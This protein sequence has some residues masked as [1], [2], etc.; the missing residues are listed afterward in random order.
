MLFQKFSSQKLGVRSQESGVKRQESGG[1]GQG[2]G[3]RGGRGSRGGKGR[4]I[5]QCP[6]PNAQCPMTKCVDKTVDF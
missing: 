2:A 6:M 3:G 5:T 1:R 4:L